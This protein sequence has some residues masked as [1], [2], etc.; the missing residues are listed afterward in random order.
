MIKK[1][2]SILL[3]VAMVVAAVSKFF[4]RGTEPGGCTGYGRYDRHL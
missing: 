4:R 2:I 3:T 1:Q